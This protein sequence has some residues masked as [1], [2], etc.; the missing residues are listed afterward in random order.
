VY[1]LNAICRHGCHRLPPGRRADI[2]VV[3]GTGAVPGVTAT[4]AGGRP[5]YFS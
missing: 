2:V 1:Y 4:V 5:V 3:D